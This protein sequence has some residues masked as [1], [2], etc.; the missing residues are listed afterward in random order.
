MADNTFGILA[1]LVFRLQCKPGWT[2]A[3]LDEDGA[4]RFVVTVPG[5]DS[6]NQE[7]RL[8]VSHFFPVPITTYNERSWCRWLF[9]M[10]RRLENHELGEWFKVGDA[11]PFAPMH[12]PGEDPYTVHEFRNEQDARTLQDG[13]VTEMD[14]TGQQRWR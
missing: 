3:L 7:R 2:F 14:I 1:S 5:F 10:C 9:E 11:R 6:Y 13:T 4:L 12:G 8:T